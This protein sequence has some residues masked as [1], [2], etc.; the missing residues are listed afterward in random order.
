M[1]FDIAHIRQDRPGQGKVIVY[2]LGGAG[3]AFKFSGGEILCIDPYLSDAVERLFGFR[4]L[5]LAPIGAGGLS[6]DRLLFTH[7]H[8]DHLDMDSFDALMQTNPDCQVLAPAS[9]ADFLEH[10]GAAYQTVAPG[11]RSQFANVRIQTVAADHGDLCPDA[12]GFLLNFSGRHLYFTGDTAWDESLMA[13]AIQVQPE[14]V[15]PC[16]NGAYGNMDETEAAMLVGRC[17]AKIAIPSHFWLFVEHGGSP[18]TFREQV[19]LHADG[20]EALLLTPGR[21]VEV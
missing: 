8:A 2:W 20:A 16:I 9:C 10:K 6:C 3:F 4:R 18:A 13:G 14:I 17:G 7:D 11:T 19:E 1:G 15:M 12:V 5:S 21:G